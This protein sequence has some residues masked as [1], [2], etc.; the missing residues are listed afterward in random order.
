[1]DIVDHSSGCHE[2][3]PITRVNFIPNQVL[4]VPITD[5]KKELLHFFL[6]S[7]AAGNGVMC[8]ADALM[9]KAIEESIATGDVESTCILIRLSKHRAVKSNH[10]CCA[11]KFGRSHILQILLE[12]DSTTF[13]R[14]NPAFLDWALCEKGK[15]TFGQSLYDYMQADGSLLSRGRYSFLHF[16]R[17]LKKYRSERRTEL[18]EKDGTRWLNADEVICQLNRKYGTGR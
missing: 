6:N 4:E 12:E 18:L 16:R 15:S 13:P 2:Y 11:V 5:S 8:C 10:F 7:K 14:D 3:G 17:G 1:M 9:Q